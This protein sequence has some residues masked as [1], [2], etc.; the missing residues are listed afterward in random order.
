MTFYSIGLL[1]SVQSKIKNKTK[2]FS[3]FDVVLFNLMLR[4]YFVSHINYK[5]HCIYMNIYA[6]VY[7]E[8]D[9]KI[10]TYIY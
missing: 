5:M 1:L 6:Y 4:K 7:I 9:F 2:H 8:R 3:I 10:Y